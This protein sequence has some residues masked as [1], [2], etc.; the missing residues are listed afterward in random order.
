MQNFKSYLIFSLLL[1]SK[2]ASAS[3]TQ[4][5]SKTLGDLMMS[6]G[7]R[8]QTNQIYCI[9]R[10][11]YFRECA[12]TFLEENKISVGEQFLLHLKEAELADYMGECSKKKDAKESVCNSSLAGLFIDFKI[13]GSNDKVA[14]KLTAWQTISDEDVKRVKSLIFAQLER[15]GVSQFAKASPENVKGGPTINKLTRQV[16]SIKMENDMHQVKIN[17]DGSTDLKDLKTG[18]IEHSCV[19]PNPGTDSTQQSGGQK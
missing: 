13:P 11:A 2:F 6:K 3:K 5:C 1:F 9:K 8:Q 17:P 10:S 12:D 15:S 7:N 18:K 19:A 14:E 4:D 16:V